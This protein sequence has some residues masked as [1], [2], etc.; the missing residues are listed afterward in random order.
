MLRN[1]I[2]LLSFTLLATFMATP[3]SE[4]VIGPDSIVFPN[5]SVVSGCPDSQQLE[6]QLVGFTSTT[7]RGD[8]GIIH[9]NRECN[10][11]FPGTRLCAIREIIETINPPSTGLANDYAWVHSESVLASGYAGLSVANLIVDHSGVLT[12]IDANAIS[13]A[14]WSYA[15][16]GAIGF[17]VDTNT[18]SIGGQTCTNEHRISCCGLVGVTAYSPP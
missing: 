13:C 14:G 9:F 1:I 5:G 18:G 17:T 3:H 8:S 10:I 16:P 7:H 4:L 2:R 6:Y 12:N 11:V 15:G